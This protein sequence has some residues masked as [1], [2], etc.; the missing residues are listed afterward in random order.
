M[1]LDGAF[2]LSD[3]TYFIK[4]KNKTC[5]EWLKNSRKERSFGVFLLS[6]P[7]TFLFEKKM[8]FLTVFLLN[9]YGHM[10]LD[11][12]VLYRKTRL[13]LPTGQTISE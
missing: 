12:I 2:R 1:K 8:T 5:F 11:F 10:P 9:L 7:I 3:F 4:K 6:C 13:I